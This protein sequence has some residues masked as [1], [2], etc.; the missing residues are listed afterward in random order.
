MKN[1]LSVLA[2]IIVIAL[3]VGLNWWL[4]QSVSAHPTGFGILNILAK[5][6]AVIMTTVIQIKAFSKASENNK[7][8]NELLFVISSITMVVFLIFGA[9]NI[10]NMSGGLL[11][12]LY[13][14]ASVFA[15]IFSVGLTSIV[16]VCLVFMIPQTI[17]E[18]L[19]DEQ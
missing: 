17:I 12:F 11:L 7:P 1:K 8:I 6:C 19:N 15:L 9:H 14:F 10:F 4:N 2:S 16:T 13:Q 5:T 3:F 18:Y